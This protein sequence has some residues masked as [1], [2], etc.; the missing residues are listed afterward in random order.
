MASNRPGPGDRSQRLR[1]PRRQQAEDGPP[2]GRHLRE[3]GFSLGRPLDQARRNAFRTCGG[4]EGLEL[5]ALLGLE[6]PF[7]SVLEGRC[8]AGLKGPHKLR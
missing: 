2:G 6:T 7:S 3:V 4:A 8:C 1:Q 5:G